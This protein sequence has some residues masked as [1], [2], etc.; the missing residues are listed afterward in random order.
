[1]CEHVCVGACDGT[2]DF[3]DSPGHCSGTCTGDCIGTCFHAV[4]G[5]P[6]PELC[7]GSCDAETPAECG[8]PTLDVFGACIFDAPTVV[9]PVTCSDFA[10]V[11]GAV[12]FQVSCQETVCLCCKANE[13]S[14]VC[15]PLETTPATACATEARVRDTLITQCMAFDQCG[16]GCPPTPPAARAACSSADIAECNYP[17]VDGPSYCTCTF[18]MFVCQ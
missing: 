12:S 16:A 10:E 18:D 7:T 4:E 6:C 9:A 8:D 5:E 11:G 17:G 14:T 3:E 1:V 2:C 15:Y 13:D